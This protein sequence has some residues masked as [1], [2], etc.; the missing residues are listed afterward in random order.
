ME[1]QTHVYETRLELPE[2]GHKPT[3]PL[4]VEGKGALTA[5]SQ[6]IMNVLDSLK[7]CKF[8]QNG[9]WTIGP[10]AEA[11]QHVTGKK[12][13]TTELILSGERSFNLKRL[14]NVDRGIGRRDDTLPKRILSLPKTAEGYTPNLP[15]LDTMLDEYYATRGWSPEGIPLPETIDR[16]QLP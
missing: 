1:G 12:A 2:I 6:N 5:L 8:A 9:G 10:L 11:Y 4:I 14:I 15:P 16:L 3:G 7:S 13:T